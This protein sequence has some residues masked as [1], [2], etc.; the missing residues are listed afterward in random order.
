MNF[1]PIAVGG[2][3]GDLNDIATDAT[4]G[5]VIFADAT[6]L[7]EDND[8]FYFDATNIRLGLN[9]GTAPGSTLSVAG[10]ESQASASGLTASAIEVE[11]Y[12]LTLTGTTQV[13]SAAG[14]A[15][16]RVGTVTITD[17]SAVTVDAAAAV[18]IEAAPVAAGSVTLTDRYALWVDAGVSR[19]DDTAEQRS[20]GLAASPTPSKGFVARNYTAAT[21]GATV[22]YS[23]RITLAG[24]VWDVDGAA[25]T[26]AYWSMEARMRSA[27]TP[28][29]YV[30]WYYG[31]GWNPWSE[32]SASLSVGREGLTISGQAYSQDDTY[33]PA[34]LSVT[35]AAH[36]SVASGTECSA[37]IF[38]GAS[39]KSWNTGAITTQRDFRI[40]AGSYAFAAGSTVTNAITFDVSGP[41]QEN[42]NAT[43]TNSIAARIAGTTTVASAAGTTVTALDIPD[44]TVTLTG[45]TTLTT[46]PSITG[47]NIGTITITDG[48]AITVNRAAGLN[49][50]AGPSVGG[51]AVI[52]QSAGL[53]V[54][55]AATLASKG[56]LES[57][58]I[59]IP[60]HTVTLTGTTQ[61][62][63][64]AA[65][66]GIRI[67][68]ITVTDAS[69]VTVNSVAAI[70]IAGAPVAAGSVTIT[71]RF[72]LFVA[73]G[74]SRMDD[75]FLMKEQAG[76]PRTAAA[77]DGLLW[78]KSTNPSALVYTDDDDTD[79]V[80]SHLPSV[81]VSSGT[82]NMAVT[83][84]LINVTYTATDVVTVNL[85]AAAT[86]KAGKVVVIVDGG[87]NAG[88]NNITIDGNSAETISGAATY[89]IS[90]DYNAVTLWCDGSNWFII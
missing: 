4:A 35:D 14:V 11:D 74:V 56:D 9:V 38:T 2:G 8:D 23:P 13:T 85:V 57:S 76:A 33:S 77:T 71:D 1:N 17:A 90:G 66:S 31:T 30:D 88:T 53:R 37:F 43:I 54:S 55:N 42:T 45:T 29:S 64:A 58:P 46:Q 89:V 44:Y 81:T 10:T 7:G 83:D 32:G 50:D 49:I 22:Q 87:G 20:D 15:G 39:G 6:G 41:P 79:V 69:A 61:L 27:N 82:H 52:Q 78:V 68:Q 75:G 80:L 51:S 67:E 65:I 62:T 36:S 16:V 84:Q 21:A 73:D 12:T 59:F 18:Y 25:S 63:T 28:A 40:A 34:A 72:A 70:Y 86:A 24:T 47:I 60:P 19:F 26:T 3:G 48:S 5:S